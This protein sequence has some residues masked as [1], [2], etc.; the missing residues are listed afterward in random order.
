MNN[1]SLIQAIEKGSLEEVKSLLESKITKSDG[2]SLLHV[3]AQ[4][5][6][7]EIVE[8]FL[9]NNHFDVNSQCKTKK[10]KQFFKTTPLMLAIDG[11]HSETVKLL[12]DR[13]ASVNVPSLSEYQDCLINASVRGDRE[14]IKLLLDHGIFVC[15]DGLGEEEKGE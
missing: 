3:A 14:I 7:T 2:D 8:F 13:G 10:G 15:P 5:G 9:D 6:Q 4:H 12:L 11:N 1:T